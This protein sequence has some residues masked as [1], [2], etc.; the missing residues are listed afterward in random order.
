MMEENS[1]ELC[2]TH[3]R[4]IFRTVTFKWYV[5]YFRVRGTG[6]VRE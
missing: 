1:D 3:K 2:W 4:R 6:G 5:E